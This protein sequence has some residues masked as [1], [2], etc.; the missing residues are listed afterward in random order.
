MPKQYRI[1]AGEFILSRT[2]RQF[3]DHPEVDAAVVVLHPDDHGFYR[4][5]AP[6]HPKLLPPVDG[7]ASRQD[8]V[9]N[10]L[11]A[12]AALREPTRNVLIHDAVRPFAS[13]ALISR[14]IARLET[15]AAALPAVAVAD[16]LKQGSAEGYTTGTVPRDHLFAAQ[17][18][19]G[20]RFDIIRDAHRRAAD[21]GAVV[22][23]DAAIAE[24]AGIPV[25]L[26]EGESGNLKLT[27][28]EEIDMADRRLSAEAAAAL[29]DV[30]VGTGYDVHAFTDGDFVTLGGIRIPHDRGLL[31]HS[32]A[33]VA[34]H[35]LTD[36][37]LGALADGDIGQ[38]FPPSDPQWKGAS[39]DRF[40]L[41][42]VR[43][44]R[45]RGGE[46]SHLDVAI[47]AEAPKIGP[48]RDAMRRR[49]AEIAGIGEG[50]VAVKATTN[51]RL[52]FI[53]RREGIAAL[54]TATIRLPW[55]PNG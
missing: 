7:G 32:D 25:R 48:H 46:V 12:L 14:V 23:D 29:G 11:A 34:L 52:G 44:V 50:R 15:D 2:L 36:A 5:A 51:E 31:G 21:A 18:P 1:L 40:L 54:A 26:V 3:L 53:G 49:I 47:A 10:G 6:Q 24:W 41:D 27:T 42:A 16:T 43:R 22:T 8:S 4:R 38:H 37:I 35:A 30:R 28:A 19:Q 17:T 20:F 13:A 39:S 33:D 55:S 9:R 45:L